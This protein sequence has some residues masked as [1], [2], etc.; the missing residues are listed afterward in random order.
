[1][2]SSDKFLNLKV[3]C[4]YCGADQVAN[5][6]E[7]PSLRIFVICWQCDAGYYRWVRPEYKKQYGKNVRES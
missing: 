6:G 5:T 4:P 7:W 2:N 1:M 3:I